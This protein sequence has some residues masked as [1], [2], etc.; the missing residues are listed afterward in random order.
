[1]FK[2]EKEEKKAVD[3]R[4]KGWSV[5][6]IARELKVSQSSISLW[7]RK[8]NLT[9]EQKTFLAKKAEDSRIKGLLSI[10]KRREEL[11][12]K[13]L[14]KV[15]EKL[16]N[17]DLDSNLCRLLC[18]FLYWGE[19]SKNSSRVSFIN[20]DPTMVKTFMFLL[21]TGFIPDEKKF[22]GLVHLHKYHNEEKV[23]EYWSK[24]SGI[25]LGQF[26]KSYIKP[27]TGKVIREGYMGSL[28]ISYYD[29]LILRELKVLY[30]EFFQQKIRDV[31]QW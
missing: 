10:K 27:N 28:D 24:M 30:Q 5:K 25:P 17:I 14:G 4:L 18:A 9:K 23:K 16:S 22:R 19:G 20:S 11:H 12:Q 15:Q 13:I 1:M 2:K 8:V 6:A 31:V 21:R 3:L 26:S 29:T 7:V